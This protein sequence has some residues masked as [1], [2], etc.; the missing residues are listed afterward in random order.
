VP[1]AFFE[2]AGPEAD[3][4]EVLHARGWKIEIAARPAP[5][6]PSPAPP[7]PSPAPV[8]PVPPAETAGTWVWAGYGTAMEWRFVSG[9]GLD[10][11]GV[12]TSTL[13]DPSGPAGVATQALLVA[14]R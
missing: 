1:T 13:S 4:Q 14:P 10:G 2:P 9:G 6:T 3:G 5:P 7:T 11:T 12:A 8:P